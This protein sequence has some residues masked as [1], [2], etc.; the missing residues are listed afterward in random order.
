M[1]GPAG[2]PG[3]PAEAALAEAIEVAVEALEERITAARWILD[4]QTMRGLTHI[5]KVTRGLGRDEQAARVLR[6]AVAR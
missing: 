2:V 1:T 3:P 6:A 5:E 4:D